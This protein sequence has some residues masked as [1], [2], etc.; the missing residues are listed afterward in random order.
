VFQKDV[1]GDAGV[2]EVGKGEETQRN[3]KSVIE[4]A[5]GSPLNRIR[6]DIELA[7]GANTW[8]SF[9]GLP[10]F[11]NNIIGAHDTGH[12]ICGDTLAVKNTAAFD[13]L[14]W[15]FHCNWDR[16]WWQW[17]R[18]AHVQHLP[19]F[20]E[21]MARTGEDAAWLDDPVIGLI[22]PFG[23]LSEVTIDSIELGVDYVLPPAF[24]DKSMF[25]VWTGGRALA[26]SVVLVPTPKVIVRL[27]GFERLGIPGSVLIELLAG[28][29]VVAS[30]YVFK[31]TAPE[32]CPTC[33][34]HGRVDID[35]EVE[36]NAIEGLEVSARVTCVGSK[37]A[38]TPF[39]LEDCGSP[40]LSVRMPLD[41]GL[42]V[43][44]Q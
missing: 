32:K 27:E 23:I 41:S 19:E 34:K 6:E 18:N 31:S 10:P 26:E 9:N 39:L 13:P 15:F 29:Q 12:G 22:E 14:F 21:L 33:R 43:L 5:I 36:R 25:N 17:Q 42:R 1:A 16:L 11:S 20:K 37:G 35:F 38:R 8:L 7:L 40:A 4:A 24:E 44:P 2:T 3:E 30:N 28:N